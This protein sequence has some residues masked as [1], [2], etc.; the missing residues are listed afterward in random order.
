MGLIL[1]RGLISE[2]IRY[3]FAKGRPQVSYPCRVIKDEDED[4]YF[5]P[6]WTARSQEILAIDPLDPVDHSGGVLK[7]CLGTLP[8]QIF[9]DSCS[10]DRCVISFAEEDPADLASKQTPEYVVGW[11]TLI[12]LGLLKGLNS[13]K[14]WTS[15]DWYGPSTETKEPIAVRLIDFFTEPLDERSFR[16]PNPGVLPTISTVAEAMDSMWADLESIL[17]RVK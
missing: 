15:P 9:G 11:R 10:E 4:F 3:L 14:D 12:P 17:Q 2:L 1:K 7:K 8:V 6:Y 16:D 5:L 13:K